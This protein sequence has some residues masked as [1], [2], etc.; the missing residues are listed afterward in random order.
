MRHFGCD[1]VKNDNHFFSLSIGIIAP[2][3]VTTIG[4]SPGAVHNA[5]LPPQKSNQQLIG[6]YSSTH[7]PKLAQ[8]KDVQLMN[9]EYN[10]VYYRSTVDVR[11]MQLDGNSLPVTGDSRE[12]FLTNE[13]AREMAAKDAWNIIQE[14]EHHKLQQQQ[15]IAI[16]QQERLAGT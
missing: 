11:V 9:Y 15:V 4:P 7:C 5:E 16:Q 10:H 3:P 14:F 12:Y 13:M 1:D 8:Y 2:Q 6:E